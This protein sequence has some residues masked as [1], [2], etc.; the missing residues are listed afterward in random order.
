MKISNFFKSPTRKRVEAKLKELTIESIKVKI[1]K[2]NHNLSDQN[3]YC[4]LVLKESELS[5][6][7]KLLNSILR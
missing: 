3:C 6:K 5:L 7:I 1:E 4:N 2:H